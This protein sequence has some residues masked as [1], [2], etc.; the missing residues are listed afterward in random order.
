MSIKTKGTEIWFVFPDSH[1]FS[2]VKLGC[3]KGFQGLSGTKSQ[4]DETCLDSQEMEFGPGMASPQAITIGLDFDDSKVS[5]RN[6]IYLDEND[7]TVTW[8]VGLSNG[9]SL[10]TINPTT[11]AVTWPTDR[12]FVDFQGYLADVPID[13]Q[14]NANVNSQ[15]SVQ[16]SG[17][18]HW[19]FKV[20]S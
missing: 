8:I 4:I 7:I 9:K 18:K 12:T 5:H 11:G 3:P 13:I 1:G 6:L 10:P 15:V 14:V 17:A 20:Y 2:L 19:H 16:R